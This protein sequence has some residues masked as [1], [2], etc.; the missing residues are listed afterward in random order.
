MLDSLWNGLKKNRIQLSMNSAVHELEHLR[1]TI[2]DL[3]MQ[4]LPNNPA[5]VHTL[6]YPTYHLSSRKNCKVLGTILSTHLIHYNFTNPTSCV[7]MANPEPLPQRA[8]WKS[9][10]LQG[11]QPVSELYHQKVVESAATHP[12]PQRLFYPFFKTKSFSTFNASS[13]PFKT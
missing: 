7:C 5:F 1:Y 2:N 3:C 6:P 12:F 11:Q 4:C 13:R 9:R 8:T 10:R